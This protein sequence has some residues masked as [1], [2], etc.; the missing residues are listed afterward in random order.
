MNSEEYL[1]ALVSYIAW[2][3]GHQDGFSGMLAVAFALRNRV[4]AGSDWLKVVTSQLI[5]RRITALPDPREP[6]F[7]R[8]LQNIDGV[9]DNSLIDNLTGGGLFYDQ[10]EG[11]PFRSQY[12]AKVGSLVFFLITQER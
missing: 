3:D 10:E 11:V 6:A 1:K 12:T 2:R 9:F 4:K 7:Q 8:L 5:E